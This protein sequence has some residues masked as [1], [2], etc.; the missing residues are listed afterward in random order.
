MEM[1][2][3][4]FYEKYKPVYNHI[5]D[6]SFT[7]GQTTGSWSGAPMYFETYGEDLSYVKSKSPEYI[8][9]L[10]DCDGRTVI[11]QGY[12][13][14]DRVAYLIASVPYVV[15]NCDEYIDQPEEELE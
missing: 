9:T 12:H 2:S 15:G 1:N 14:V 6:S 11:E 8:W 3:D 4:K 13:Y 7:E 10:L 5:E